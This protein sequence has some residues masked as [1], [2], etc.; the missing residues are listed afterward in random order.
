MKSNSS[1]STAQVRQS[2]TS[3]AKAKKTTSSPATAKRS[4]NKTAP[5]APAP[6]ELPREFAELETLLGYRFRRP[7]LLREALTHRSWRAGM[8][9]GTPEAEAPDN[10]RLEFL[11][12]AVLA[13]R[14][15]E[16]M[17]AAFPQSTEGHLSRLRA[18]IVSARYLAEVA[19][20]LQLGRFLLLSRGEEHIGGR[21]KERLLANGMEA[22]LG[23]VHQ[24]GG[25]RSSSRQIDRHVIGTCLETLSPEHVHEFAYK[26]VLQEWAHAQGKPQ[27]VYRIVGVSGPEHSKTFTVE[28][29]I[30]GVY[31]GQAEAHSR[32]DGEQHA[33]HDALVQLGRI[34]SGPA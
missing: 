32:K 24:D 21:S 23:A 2:R 29:E 8:K 22:I 18:W 31:R 28:V 4:R 13:L 16:R 17:L 11:G 27:P 9:P 10:E 26:S 19:Q 5:T 7:E 34:P 33:A 1:K 25:Y 3:G 20:K 12:D 14:T 6:A 30:S 15:S